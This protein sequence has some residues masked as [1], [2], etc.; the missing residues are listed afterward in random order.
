MLSAQRLAAALQGTKA[1]CLELLIDVDYG[2]GPVY[3]TAL[4]FTFGADGAGDECH[5][6]KL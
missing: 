4:A 3:L 2:R 5:T 1:R 6:L